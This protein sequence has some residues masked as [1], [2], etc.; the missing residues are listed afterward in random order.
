MT[1]VCQS[2][3]V[4]LYIFN[5]QMGNICERASVRTTSSVEIFISFC[6]LETAY[7]E[8]QFEHSPPV[9][10]DIYIGLDMN[11]F[12]VTLFSLFAVEMVMVSF[13]LIIVAK[14]FL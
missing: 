9:K 1:S 4:Y 10:V 6:Q 8:L 12:V 3:V 5:L 14:I 13:S 2:H 11:F 7:V